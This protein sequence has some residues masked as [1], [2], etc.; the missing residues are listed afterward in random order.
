MHQHCISIELHWTSRYQAAAL[1]CIPDSRKVEARHSLLQDRRKCARYDFP[2][3]TRR[4][5][6]SYSNYSI[7]HF[8]FV[9]FGTALTRSAC[10]QFDQDGDWMVDPNLAPTPMKG[11][12]APRRIVSHYQLFST[13]FVAPHVQPSRTSSTAFAMSKQSRLSS[14]RYTVSTGRHSIEK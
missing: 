9:S 1:Y 4:I 13:I 2:S 7:S 14:Y 10:R 3:P 8:L 12:P 6:V 11:V 5:Q